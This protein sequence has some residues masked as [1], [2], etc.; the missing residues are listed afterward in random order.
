MTEQSKKLEISKFVIE[1]IGKKYKT[2]SDNIPDFQ[3][4]SGTLSLLKKAREVALDLS[5]IKEKEDAPLFGVDSKEVEKNLTPKI[6]SVL[7]MHIVDS[8]DDT[9]AISNYARKHNTSFEKVTKLR[10]Q[11]NKQE[12]VITAT[13]NKDTAEYDNACDKITEITNNF[14]SQSLTLINE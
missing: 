6:L 2:I 7:D 5:G 9:I 13:P 4:L 8:Y 1:T 3:V 14:I 12:K 10:N 11:F